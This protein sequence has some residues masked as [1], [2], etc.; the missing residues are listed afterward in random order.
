M[1]YSVSGTETGVV[2]GLFQ[3]QNQILFFYRMYFSI[4]ESKRP[5]GVYL[6]DFFCSGL[7]F[8][9]FV[10]QRFVGKSMRQA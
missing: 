3:T 1:T 4:C 7:Q 5:T 9:L 6:L 2:L 8:M 10:A